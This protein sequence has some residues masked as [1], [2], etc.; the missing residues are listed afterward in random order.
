MAAFLD[1]CR[2]IPTAGGTTDWI[3][4]S[5]VGGCQSPSLAGAIDGRRYKFIAISSDLTQ[6]EIA[7]GA[8]TAAS[9]TFAR[10]TVLYNSSGSGA[11]SGQS[12]AGTKISFTAAPN[13]AI[14]AVKEDLI[15]IEEPNAFT[16]TQMAQ[17]RANLGVTKRNY[18]VNGGMQISQ[19]N[20]VSAGSTNLYYPVD[21]W[22]IQHT[23]TTG[24][25]SC[26]QVNVNTPGGSPWRIRV[27]VGTAQ[28]TSGGQVCFLQQRLEGVRVADLMWGTAAARTVTIQVGVKAPV[29]GTYVVQLQNAATD[30]T[31]VGSFTVAAGEINTDV[32]KSVTL[33]GA[34]TG[35]WA[36]DTSLGMYLYLY[37][38]NGGQTANAFATAGNVFEL[39]D[40][41]MYEGNVAPPF[42]LPDYL[43]ELG[44]CQRYY[45]K[46]AAGAQTYNGS[47]STQ[48]MAA[49]TP[50]PVCMRATPTCAVS[51]G[52]IQ[53]AG[54]DFVTSYASSIAA[55]TWYN[56]VS[57]IANARL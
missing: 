57:V 40:A 21:Q 53:V 2:F 50:L 32:V 45:V 42:Q 12:G 41:G 6:W 18:L 9:G 30:T 46:I 24:T 44:I 43:T 47:A 7:E 49:T 29:A 17:A 55:A 13:V 16:T 34:T 38:M 1:N 51:T 28:P 15:S 26:S 39:F 48:Q 35:T 5:A 20:G 11:G 33:A 19:E 56:P 3:Y 8:Y 23:M 10:T 4:S 54:I 14:V 36:R 52:A 22:Y 25:F 27:T 37:L 31:V